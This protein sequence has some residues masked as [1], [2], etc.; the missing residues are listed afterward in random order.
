MGRAISEEGRRLE[1]RGTGTGALYKPW[2]KCRELNSTGVATSFPD[3]KHGRMVE[4]LSQAELWW[5]VVLRWDDD[6]IDIREQFPLDKERTDGI[7]RRYGFRLFAGGFRGFGRR[8]SLLGSFD[9]LF[10]GRRGDFDGLFLGLSGSGFE[11][12]VPGLGSLS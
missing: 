11:L 3:W 12:L 1:G 7:A 9:S 5:Y 8:G 10:F 2:I 6:V 4:L